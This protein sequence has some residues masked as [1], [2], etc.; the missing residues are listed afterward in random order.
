VE[1][2]YNRVKYHAKKKEATMQ[3][4][5]PPIEE[6]IRPFVELL[7]FLLQFWPVAIIFLICIVVW[8]VM[9]LIGTDPGPGR[10]RP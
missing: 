10:D 3:G 1:K 6:N 5:T 9:N 7:L 2:L 8:I 4:L